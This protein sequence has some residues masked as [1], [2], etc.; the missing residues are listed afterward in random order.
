MGQFLSATPER[1]CLPSRPRLSCSKPRTTG[2]RLFPRQERHRLARRRPGAARYRHR[3][4][5]ARGRAAG[6]R[7]DSIERFAEVRTPRSSGEGELMTIRRWQLPLMLAVV[8]RVA[9][10]CSSR[11]LRSRHRPRARPLRRRRSQPRR[12]PP[13]QPRRRRQLRMRAERR[14]PQLR[15]ADEQYDGAEAGSRPSPRRIANRLRERLERS[16]PSSRTQRRQA[17]RRRQVGDR[18]R[19]QLLRVLRRG[20]EQR[21]AA[22]RCRWRRAAPASPSASRSASAP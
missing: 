12:P 14:G 15:A 2:L 8:F 19:R 5:E 21:P 7:Q 9:A 10:A 1:A 11:R 22:R 18:R 17:D 16:P 4:Q 6:R 13:N 3:P 20:G